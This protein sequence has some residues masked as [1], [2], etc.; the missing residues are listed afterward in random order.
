MR[1]RFLATWWMCWTVI[2]TASVLLVRLPRRLGATKQLTDK[3]IVFAMMGLYFIPLT[4]GAPPLSP[5][6]PLVGL[7]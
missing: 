1:R 7:C 5:L 4:D 2:D 3:L 6:E